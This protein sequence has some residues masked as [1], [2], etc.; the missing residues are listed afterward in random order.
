[1]PFISKTFETFSPITKFKNNTKETIM[2][3]LEQQYFL[4]GSNGE[5]EMQQKFLTQD[6]AKD[7]YDRQMLEYL[8]PT[9]QTFIA[10]QE[11]VF[12]STSDQHGECDCS[13]RSGEAGFVTVLDDKRV[14]YPDYRGNGVL[15]SV[16][17]M[18][19]N[20]HIGML[21]I[22][23]FNDKVGLHVNGKATIL[24]ESQLLALLKETHH[25][26]ALVAETS[27][28]QK[29]VFWVLVHVEEAYIHCSKNIPVLKKNDDSAL[30]N[31][32]RPIDY[33]ELSNTKI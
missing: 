13:F 17:N 16:G 23:F 7:F 5:H 20:P 21:F 11:M 1:M 26:A 32:G 30:M 6:K 19:E 3:T 12:I 18:S 22:D 8:A 28:T 25:D 2:S 31:K 29:T 10:R 14:I 15:A 24:D 27:S 9:M 4:P 33:F